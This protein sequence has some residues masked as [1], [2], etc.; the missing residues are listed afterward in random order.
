MRLSRANG[1]NLSVRAYDN[2]VLSSSRN[3]KME[4]T[5]IKDIKGYNGDYKVDE[6]GNVWSFKYKEPRILAT[7]L[8]SSPYKQVHLCLNNEIKKY[9]VHRLVAET[10]LKN[11]DNLQIVHHKDGDT[12]NNRVDN[13]EWTTQQKNVHESYINTGLG[14]TRNAIKVRLYNGD[15]LVGEF[16]N[17]KEAC[18][19]AQ[20]LGASFTMLEKHKKHGA[21]RLEKV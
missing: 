10:Y 5:K 9:L 15:E 7:W 11:P 14:A 19:E 17:Q 21:F 4:G 2:P 16:S 13:L 12:L 20:K 3:S 18:R 6:E 1:G 8:G